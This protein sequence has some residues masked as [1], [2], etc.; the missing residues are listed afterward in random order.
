M[1]R[2]TQDFKV[3]Q[4]TAFDIVR[5]EGPLDN[6]R[7]PDGKNWTITDLCVLR[8]WMNR[9]IRYQKDSVTHGTRDGQT[10][11]IRVLKTRKEDCED[12]GML[13]GSL[14]QSLGAYCRLVSVYSGSNGHAFSEV[15]L[16]HSSTV[17]MAKVEKEMCQHQVL[18]LQ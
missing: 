18:K 11:P 14:A 10:G 8:E 17:N 13:F 16:G 12:H 5:S 4:K 3:I 9:N 15:C 2:R 7:N 6:R 1:A